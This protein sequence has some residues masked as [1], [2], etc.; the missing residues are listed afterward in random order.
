MDNCTSAELSDPTESKTFPLVLTL[1]QS[2]SGKQYPTIYCLHYSY[3][4]CSKFSL[5]KAWHKYLQLCQKDACFTYMNS[6]VTLGNGVLFLAKVLHIRLR[7]NI[8]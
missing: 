3:G 7:L 8:S 6:P 5:Y 2:D 1:P 4:I